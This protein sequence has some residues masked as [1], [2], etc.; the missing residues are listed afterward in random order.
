MEVIMKKIG[1]GLLIVAMLLLIFGLVMSILK[2]DFVDNNIKNNNSETEEMEFDENYI[3]RSEEEKQIQQSTGNYNYK[4]NSSLK[5]AEERTVD[6]LQ[7]T[8]PRVVRFKQNDYSFS[9]NLTNN[10]SSDYLA[11]TFSIVFLTKKGKT[12]AKLEANVYALAPGQMASIAIST[13]R[14]ILDAYDFQITRTG[15]YVPESS[16][17]TNPEP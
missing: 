14:N 9:C 8:N 4:I 5:L 10:T 6:G 17:I 2:V 3:N 11:S 12:L 7:L 13:R 1:I 16:D 15:D